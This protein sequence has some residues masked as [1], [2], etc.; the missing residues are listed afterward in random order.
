[1][2]FWDVVIAVA[3]IAAIVLY[4]ALLHR[5]DVEADKMAMELTQE[6]WDS[7]R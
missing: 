7:I 6:Q 4:G 3:L 5:H 2:R 1:M